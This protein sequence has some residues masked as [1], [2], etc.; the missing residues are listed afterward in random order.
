MKAILWL[1]VCGSGVLALAFMGGVIAA[2]RMRPVP[3][4]APVVYSPP[5][6]QRPVIQAPQ[7]HFEPQPYVPIPYTPIQMVPIIPAQPAPWVN[8]NQYNSFHE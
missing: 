3:V 8:V 7:Y 4:P 2:D 1:L 6:I 5:A